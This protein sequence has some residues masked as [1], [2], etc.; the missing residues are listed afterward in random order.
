[1]NSFVLN[2]YFTLVDK[3]FPERQKILEQG[4]KIFGPG[5]HIGQGLAKIK[6]TMLFWYSQNTNA[7]LD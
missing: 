2:H 4:V 6:K 1:M 3:S 5:N 7:Y